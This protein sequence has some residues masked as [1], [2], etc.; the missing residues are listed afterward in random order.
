L[1]N[2]IQDSYLERIEK[3]FG[4]LYLSDFGFEKTDNGNYMLVDEETEEQ[5]LHNKM[6]FSKAHQLE[7]K[8][9][10]ELWQIIEGKKYKEYKDYD[11]SDL[12]GWWD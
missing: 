2:K 7:A 1:E 8:E 10:K 3:E 12:R 5:K 11:G 6:I 9:W 4:E